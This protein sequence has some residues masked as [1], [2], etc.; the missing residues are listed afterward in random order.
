MST[1]DTTVVILGLFVVILG[2]AAVLYL[3]HTKEQA[4]SAEHPES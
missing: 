3:R 4:S 2:I 1:T